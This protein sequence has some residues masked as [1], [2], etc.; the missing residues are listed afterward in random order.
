MRHMNHFEL[1]KN[2]IVNN[3]VFQFIRFSDG[4]IEIIRNRVSKIEKGVVIF[5]GKK[6]SH[7]YP[8]WD[9]KSFNPKHDQ[10]LR[11][12]LLLAATHRDKNYYK[13]IPTRHNK[14]VSDRELMIRLNSFYD[15]NLTFSDLFLSENYLRFRKDILPLIFNKKNIFIIS[16]YRSKLSSEISHAV[17]LPIPDNAFENHEDIIFNLMMKLKKIPSKSMIISSASSISNII[18]FL[19]NKEGLD[20]SFIDVGTSINDYLGLE[21]GNRQYHSILESKDKPYKKRRYLKKLKW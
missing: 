21:M 4:E 19:I 14:A 9:Y 15:S 6:I 1:F 16:N 12:D 18:G 13:G 2:F 3:D 11:H 7:S 5:K 17:H 20:I 8:Q 10:T